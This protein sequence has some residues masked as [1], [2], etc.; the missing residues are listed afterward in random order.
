MARGPGDTLLLTKPLG[1][2]LLTTAARKQAADPKALQQAV[3]S[4][5]RLHAETHRI[6]E[7]QG[8]A[9]HGVTDITGFGL[10]GHAHEMAN[11]SELSL[12]FDIARLPLLPGAMEC[13]HAGHVPG[14]TRRNRDYFGMHCVPQEP[15]EGWAE[16]LF[17]PQTSGG[18]LVAAAPEAAARI[19]EACRAAGQTCWEVGAAVAGHPGRIELIDNSASTS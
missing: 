6:L 19:L 15:R 17:D 7:Q 8:D 14:G 9:V 5:R 10:V 4:M 1:T 12:R 2:G 18:L 16:I 3:D 11:G 13:V